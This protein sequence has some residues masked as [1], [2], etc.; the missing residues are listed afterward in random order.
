MKTDVILKL[1]ELSRIKLTEEE[2]KNFAKEIDSILSYISQ[3]QKVA[4]KDASSAIP[5][6]INVMREDTDPHEPALF[7][8]ILLSAAPNRHGQYFKVK[9]IF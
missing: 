3:I 7:T 9:N 8:E 2:K 5:G 6:E 4:P 1:A